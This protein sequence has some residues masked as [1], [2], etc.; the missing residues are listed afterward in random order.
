[1]HTFN[2]SIRRQRQVDCSE[3]QASVGYAGVSNQSRLHNE[4]VYKT[5]KDFRLKRRINN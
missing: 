1:M 5:K 4:T 3:F 2:P